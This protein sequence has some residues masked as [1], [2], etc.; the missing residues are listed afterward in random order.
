MRSGKILQI[1]KKDK[2]NRSVTLKNNRKEPP[3]MKNLSNRFK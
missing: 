1:K 2:G 3:I